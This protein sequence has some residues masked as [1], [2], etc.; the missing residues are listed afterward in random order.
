MKFVELEFEGVDA[1]AVSTYISIFEQD[2]KQ[3]PTTAAYNLQRS[4][5]RPNR[6]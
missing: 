5:E 2:F 3:D 4:L 6:S 1:H